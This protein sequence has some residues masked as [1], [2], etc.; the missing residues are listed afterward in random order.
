[1]PWKKKQKIENGE[2][3]SNAA[4]PMKKSKISGMTPVAKERSV[5]RQKGKCAKKEPPSYAAGSEEQSWYLEILHI[6]RVIC[7][8]CHSV[9]RKT[10]EGLKKHISNCRKEPYICRQ[11]GKQLHSLSGM[12]Y[13]VVAD[14]SDVPVLVSVDDFNAPSI[15]QTLRKVLKRIGRL[16]CPLEGCPGTFTS[17][18]GY[19]YHAKKCGKKESELDKMV[20]K[21]RHCEKAYRSRAGLMYHLKSEHGEITLI[22]GAGKPDE[23][24]AE[25]QD[26]GRVQRRSAKVASFHLQAIACEELIKEWPKKKVLQDLVPD[27]RKLKYSRPGLPSF[28]PEVLRKWRS[29]MKRNRKIRCPNQGCSSVYSSISGLKAHL[30]SCAQGDFVAGKYRCLLCDKEFISESGVKYHINSMHAEDW[31]VVNS[32]ANRTLQKLLKSPAEKGKK[33]QKKRTCSGKMKIRKPV[34]TLP[35]SSESPV[36]EGGDEQQ[37]GPCLG[38]EDPGPLSSSLEENAESSQEIARQEPKPSTSRAR[39][40]ILKRS[41]SPTLIQSPAKSCTAEQSVASRGKRAKRLRPV[42]VGH[43]LVL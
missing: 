27:D 17:V 29:D 35:D 3:G 16:K 9:S 37:E 18:M 41:L 5:M 31:F 40:P 6:G 15:R 43:Q 39:K 12:K 14:H 11:C 34:T 20:L 21:C 33:L 38:K 2:D 19:L 28:S 24:M 42:K 13:H 1:M 7:P 26:L 8:K 4:F 10:V 32:K 25:A 36:M 23:H 30:G 22:A